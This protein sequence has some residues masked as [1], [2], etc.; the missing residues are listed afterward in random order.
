[1]TIR[2]SI[3]FIFA[4]LVATSD[5]GSI[6]TNGQSLSAKWAIEKPVTTFD[7]QTNT[8]TLTFEVDDSVAQANVAA[9][10]WEQGCMEGGNE[11]LAAGGIEGIATAVDTNGEAT[12]TFDLNTQILVQ[13]EDVFTSL[14]AENSAEMKICARFMLQTDDGSLEVNYL[15]NVITITF[16]LT[17]GIELEGFSVQVKERDDPTIVDKDYDVEA[18]LCNPDFPSVELTDLTFTQG[19]VI[20]V[21]VT[22]SAEALA[23]GLLIETID[24]F[25]WAR[26]FIE[27]PAIE[28]S[29][30]AA[31]QLT[32]F[33][34]APG[35]IYCM[36]SSMLFADFYRPPTGAPSNSPTTVPSQG[37]TICD[38]VHQSSTTT[39]NFF[40]SVVKQSDLESG[41][42]VRFGNIGIIDGEP[43]DL[44]ITSTDY[45]NPN[46]KANANGKGPTGT[47]GKIN[48]QT[49]EN[50]PTSGQATFEFCFVQDNTYTT[51]MAESFQWSVFDLDNRGGNPGIKEK[52][53]ID[54]SQASGYSLYP[55]KDDTE[56]DLACENDGSWPPCDEGV[57]TIFSATTKGNGQDNP[58]DPDDLTEQ[59]MKRSVVFT[60]TNTSCW[61]MEFSANC[62]SEPEESCG[63]YGGSN[64]LFAGSA[65]QI[66]EWGET[67]C[68]T[69]QEERRSTRHLGDNSAEVGGSGTTTLAF[70]GSRRLT[71]DGRVLQAEAGPKASIELLVGIRETEDE[72]VV[73]RTAG[74]SSAL[75]SL[76]LFILGLLFNVAILLL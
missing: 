1:M 13:N 3:L 37:A 53:T 14:P 29:V 7:V 45:S 39:L 59:Q 21:C 36:F 27:Q 25:N 65:S 23:D 22:P 69:V 55:N 16:D 68:T 76:L 30:Q 43:V 47:F 63:W 56:V 31:N 34:C 40:D 8:F 28:G 57:R 6:V 18:Y 19:S 60:F 33:V 51:V 48:V 26:G 66:V 9:T 24:T 2:S 61:T 11:L 58:A 72:Y 46:I 17:A 49:V 41:G 64:L 54:T 50:D 15:E 71:K 75:P 42:E 74:G 52:M 5:F 12:L 32:S 44:L 38:G 10:I 35:S 70:A 62:P 67:D 4:A 20:T 73:L